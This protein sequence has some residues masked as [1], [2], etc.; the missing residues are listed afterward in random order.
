MLV[1]YFLAN[2][3]GDKARYKNINIT[4]FKLPDTF[5]K[6]AQISLTGSVVFNASRNVIIENVLFFLSYTLSF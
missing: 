5:V 1:V 3:Y 6:L 2:R 4:L